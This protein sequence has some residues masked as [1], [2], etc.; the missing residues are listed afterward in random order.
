MTPHRKRHEVLLNKY[1]THILLLSAFF[2]FNGKA[3]ICYIISAFGAS[4]VAQIVKDLLA[5]Q[6]T[7]FDAWVGKIPWRRKW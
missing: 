1:L 4:L 3:N 6:E 2:F 7:W 5:K